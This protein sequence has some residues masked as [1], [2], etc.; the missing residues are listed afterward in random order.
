MDSVFFE[1]LYSNEWI[2]S[3]FSI[4]SWL[5]T[6]FFPFSGAQNPPTKV[7]IIRHLVPDRDRRALG[8][9]RRDIHGFTKKRGEKNPAWSTYKKLLKTIENYI[10]TSTITHSL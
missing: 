6:H 5:N 9:L 7:W 1:I 2:R 3:G 8:V 4:F 10:D